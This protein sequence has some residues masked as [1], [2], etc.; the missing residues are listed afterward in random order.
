MKQFI[1]DVDAPL[2]ESFT[3]TNFMNNVDYHLIHK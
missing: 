3:A 1:L 2:E